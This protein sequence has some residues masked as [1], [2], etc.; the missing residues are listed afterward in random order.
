MAKRLF[1]CYLLTSLQPRY[2]QHTYIGFTVN[3][4]RRIRQHNGEISAGAKK[5]RTKRPWYREA[6]GACF[7]CLQHVSVHV[8]GSNHLHTVLLRC[9][10]D[11][12]VGAWL[13]Q[14]DCCVAV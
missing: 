6:S 14:Q 9:K 10:G 11:G 1:A 7:A 2:A 12:G 13:S 3:P 5:T 8:N 4:Q